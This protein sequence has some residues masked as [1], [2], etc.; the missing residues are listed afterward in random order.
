MNGNPA[1]APV[2]TELH[3]PARH[4]LLSLLPPRWRKARARPPADGAVDD[5]GEC[6]RA[7]P[8]ISGVIDDETDDGSVII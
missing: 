4:P 2:D 1:A 3:A 8:A 7:V 6:V 5:G